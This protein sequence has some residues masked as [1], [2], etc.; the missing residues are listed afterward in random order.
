M[1]NSSR[2]VG[3]N[4]VGLDERLKRTDLSQEAK[5]ALKRTFTKEVRL[6][7]GSLWRSEGAPRDELVFVRSGLLEKFRLSELG[8]RTIGLRFPGEAILPGDTPALYATRALVDSEIIIAPKQAVDDVV[9][10]F[11]D[12]AALFW[13][14]ADR[15]AAIT[16]E[17]LFNQ[18]SKRASSRVAHLFCETAWRSG[19]APKSLLNPF[20][21]LQIAKITGQTS[22]N[23]NRVIMELERTGLIGREGRNILF[24]DWD[25]LCRL[26]RFDYAYLKSM[27]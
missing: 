22:V 18:S 10:R 13:K 15:Y 3:L 6:A 23:V 26:A 8:S 21:Q 11:T 20:T 25:D 12:V 7:S 27:H 4:P 5:D 24:H 17:W 16:A 19:S 9:A 1:V 14:A 2:S